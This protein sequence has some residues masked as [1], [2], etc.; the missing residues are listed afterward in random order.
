MSS[1]VRVISLPIL[2]PADGR[3][4]DELG[5]LLR[6]TWRDAARAANYII[7]ALYAADQA[8]KQSGDDIPKMPK[9]NTYALVR[10]LLPDLPVN[11]VSAIDRETRRR[12]A[13]KNSKGQGVRWSAMVGAASLP[14]FREPFPFPVKAGDW[15]AELGD[16][17]NPIV[18]VTLKRDPVGGK[19]RVSPYR[20][21]LMLK[22]SGGHR[23]AAAL[24]R[25]IVNGELKARTLKIVA[26]KREGRSVPMV[27]IAYDQPCEEPGEVKGKLCV[28][29]DDRSLLVAAPS[30]DADAQRIWWYHADHGRRW[31]H[32]H[33]RRMQRLAD[34]YKHEPRRVRH[35]VEHRRELWVRKHADRMDTLCH[36]C[37]ARLVGFASRRRVAE[38]ELDMSE[39]GFASSFPYF[40]LKELIG[41]KCER[42]GITLRV[43][44]V[45]P[46]EKEAS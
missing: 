15:R 38:I 32:E 21:A 16:N 40:K 43:V 2:K 31:Q 35:E 29:T 5:R 10:R 13:G 26:A 37:A 23:R 19:G 25:Q 4:W 45:E 39:R 42:A 11:T 28:R 6:E 18:W 22:S 33:A 34:D 20:V 44:S 3:S 36:Q 41:Q 8:A 9:Q 30:G 46:E 14:S 12:Y 7:S 17:D 1:T 24:F 27:A